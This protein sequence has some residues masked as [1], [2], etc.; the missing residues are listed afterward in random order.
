MCT[1]VIYQGSS[2]MAVS[3]S[4]AQ[5]PSPDDPHHLANLRSLVARVMADGKISAAEAAELRTALMADG[6]ITPEEIE[7]I[8]AVMKTHLGDSH[9][10]FEQ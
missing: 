7:V 6:Q 2:T 5:T 3:P 9:L 1:N 4:S 10:E 8:R